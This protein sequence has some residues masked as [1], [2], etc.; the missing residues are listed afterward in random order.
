MAVLKT[1]VYITLSKA[2]YETK[3]KVVTA[4]SIKPSGNTQNS[5]PRVVL[6]VDIEIDDSLFDPVIDTNTVIAVGGKSTAKQ[7]KK[8]EVEPENVIAGLREINKTMK[9]I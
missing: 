7:Q 3:P 5:A 4:S 8:V 2:S 1:P 9:K 6:K